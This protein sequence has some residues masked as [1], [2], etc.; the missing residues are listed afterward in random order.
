MSIWQEMR[1]AIRK[2]ILI[3]D[4]VERLREDVAKVAAAL[5]GH[6]RRLVRIETVIEMARGARLPR[7]R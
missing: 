7:D 6:D 4:R 3:Q 5:E 1:D 2:A